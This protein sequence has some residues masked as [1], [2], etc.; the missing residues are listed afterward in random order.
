[1]PIGKGVL[2]RYKLALF[3]TLCAE[4]DTTRMPLKNNSHLLQ[5]GKEGAFC[6]S[7][8]FT[9]GAALFFGQTLAGYRLTSHCA[10]TAD[11]TDF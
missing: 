11:G 6:G 1:L 3:D 2:G 10:F 4:V 7:A 5:I 9:T 8:D